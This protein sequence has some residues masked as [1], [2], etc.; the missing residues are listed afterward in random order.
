MNPMQQEIQYLNNKIKNLFEENMKLKSQIEGITQEMKPGN[1]H[2][3]TAYGETNEIKKSLETLTKKYQDH[4]KTSNKNTINIENNIRY[5]NKE[6]AKQANQISRQMKSFEKT[7]SSVKEF[8]G[9]A[10]GLADSGSL[11]FIVGKTE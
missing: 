7:D 10:D 3:P 4:S 1:N 8:W 5:I 6:L 9:L 2:T 11:W